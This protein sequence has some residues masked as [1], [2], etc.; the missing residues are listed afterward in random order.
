VQHGA[1]ES[2]EY[3]GIAAWVMCSY[4]RLLDGEKAYG[5]LNHILSRSS[6]PNLFAVGHRGRERKMF[7]TD[8]NFGATSAIAEM[9]LQSHA[10]AIH[11]LPALPSALPDGTVKGLRGRAG[12][13]VDLS[14]ADGQLKNAV[15]KSLRGG[16][17]K[18]KYG[19]KQI[20]FTTVAGQQYRFDGSLKQL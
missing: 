3:Q 19:N 17:C 20:K 12:F 1:A 14:W 8:V 15:I 5:I 6:W 18:V 16:P 11:V 13:E 7:E 2:L 4:T 10:G 9:L